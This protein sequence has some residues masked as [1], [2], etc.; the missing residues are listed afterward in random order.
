MKTCRENALDLSPAKRIQLVET[1]FSTVNMSSDSHEC[2][3]G[4]DEIQE[5]DDEQWNELT[6]LIDL[7]PKIPAN[8]VN[9]VSEAPNQCYSA[10]YTKLANNAFTHELHRKLFISHVPN[11][12]SHKNTPKI[13]SMEYAWMTGA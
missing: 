2:S 4:L 3:A 1:I 9:F 8:N 5:F 12:L 10:S 7:Q 13:C 11:V 6:S